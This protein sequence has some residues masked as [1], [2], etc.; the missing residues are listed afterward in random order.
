MHS[1]QLDRQ[2]EAIHLFA[3][4]RHLAHRIDSAWSYGLGS[5]TKERHR[6]FYGQRRKLQLLLSAQV[7][8]GPARHEYKQTGTSL[9]QASD[10]R[11]TV[12]DLLEIVEHQ[13]E[14]LALQERVHLLC[15]WRAH[16][17]TDPEHL[18][19]HAGN[20]RCIA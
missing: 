14:M 1:S 8:R 20:Q 15:K 16:L 12:Q 11:R 13:Q 17:F 6:V 2:G 18:S 7:Q 5:L 9:Q 4:G 10:E 19:K 3:D